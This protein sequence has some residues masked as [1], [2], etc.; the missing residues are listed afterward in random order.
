WTAAGDPTSAGSPFG[1]LGQAIRRAASLIDSD[2]P[3]DREAQLRRWVARRVEAA[4][5]SRVT[6]FIGEL[7]GAHVGDDTSVQLHAARRE[8]GLM[9]DQMRH[10]FTDLLRA[11]CD[12]APLV[13]VLD[14]LHW[15]D[16]PTM[17]FVETALTQLGERPCLVLA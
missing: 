2:S 16:R 11:E 5:M 8:P 3:A 9:G 14:D 6:A 13:L 17:S 12:A 7:V 15:S 10:A 4:Q 1:L